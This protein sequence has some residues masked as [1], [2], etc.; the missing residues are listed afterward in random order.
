MDANSRY[1]N[2]ARPTAEP[3][4][5][6]YKLDDSSAESSASKPASPENKEPSGEETD[7]MEF[8][9]SGYKVIVPEPEPEPESLT[10][11]STDAQPQLPGD[12]KKNTKKKKTIVKPPTPE[13]PAPEP[14]ITEPQNSEPPIT[15]PPITE[16]PVPEPQTEP[17]SKLTKKP[18]MVYVAA[19]AGIGVLLGLVIAYWV[20]GNSGQYDLGAYTSSATGLKGHLSTKWEKK[21]MYRLTIEPSDKSRA[22]RI[23]I[24]RSQFAGSAFHRNSLAGFT[25][26]CL[27]QQRDH[28]E[29]QRRDCGN[30]SRIN[31]G[32]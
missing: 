32:R 23:R 22:R 28:T 13:P 8:H 11:I 3:P 1:P 26:R 6:N 21:P 29:I 18:V 9:Y 19:V 20:M 5:P 12:A 25:W 16:P 31:C 4:R 24:G 10:G 17:V 2:R 7:E 27:M 30:S 14:P 15:E